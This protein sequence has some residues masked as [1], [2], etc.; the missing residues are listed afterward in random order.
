M[1]DQ[2]SE[3]SGPGGDS[4]WGP[5]DNAEAH[6]GL[7]I[8]PGQ[9]ERVRNSGIP[10]HLRGVTASQ[11]A[12][13]PSPGNPA[14]QAP[15]GGWNAMPTPPSAVV[16]G[17]ST[18]GSSTPG[19]PARILLWSGILVAHLP[20]IVLLPLVIT[21]ERLV[22]LSAYPLISVMA[23]VLSL[24][25]VG[26]AFLLAR[27]TT[28]AKRLIGGGIYAVAGVLALVVPPA[29]NRLMLM[30]MYDF[31]P[32]M[33]IHSLIFIVFSMGITAAM[34]IAWNIARNRRWWVHLMAAGLAILFGTFSTT[35]QLLF[36][37]S[38]V[39]PVLATVSTQLL[40]LVLMYGSLI[41][42]HACGRMNG[43]SVP[44]EG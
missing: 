24:L 33:W 3:R 21:G 22:I 16:S 20:G 10:A 28:W 8:L 18:P 12:Q 7:G 30:M 2:R 4:D 25:V 42:L 34:L 11:D 36:N 40:A 5:G 6:F 37:I 38:G 29:L 15:I 27:N 17:S 39:P 14:V 35:V 23:G 26:G 32:G 41:L 9:Q 1:S 31:G 19:W 43:G 13:V 44:S